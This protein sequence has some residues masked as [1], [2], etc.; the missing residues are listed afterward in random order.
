M[1]GDPGFERAVADLGVRH[2]VLAGLTTEGCVLRTSVGALQRDYGVTVVVDA[3]AGATQVGHDTALTTLGRYGVN[4]TTWLSLA[5]ELQ[6]TYDDEKTVD[7]FRSVQNLDPSFAKN[8][9]QL[10]SALSIGAR[11]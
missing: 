11:G 10:A 2:L 6:V 5:A 1:P 3:S 9:E 8:T 7:V 4:F